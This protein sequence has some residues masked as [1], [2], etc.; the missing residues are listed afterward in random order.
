MCMCICVC[1]GGAYVYMSPGAHRRDKSSSDPLQLG[2]Q[3]GVSLLMWELET[4]L[5][6]S[7]RAASA[8]DHLTACSL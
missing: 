4:K 8:P 2:L 5:P 1:G 7:V 6:F 3:A